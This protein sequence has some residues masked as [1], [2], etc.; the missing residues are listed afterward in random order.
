M[1]FVYLA[2]LIA[3]LGCLALLDRRFTLFLWRD[4]WRAAGVLAGGLVFFLAWDLFGIG[5]GI[6]SRGESR[7]MTGIVV[8]PELPL[9]EVFFL[10][11]LSYLTMILIT[12][13][14]RVL[15]T[16]RGRP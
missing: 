9:E 10:T 11:F 16:K 4:G 14:G 12:G 2:L 5:M 1:S 3:V 6:F 7:I 8:A 15:H 13:L